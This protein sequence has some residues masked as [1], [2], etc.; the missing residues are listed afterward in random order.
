MSAVKDYYGDS[1]NLVVD[2]NLELQGQEKVR[3]I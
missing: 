1:V 3:I 2:S